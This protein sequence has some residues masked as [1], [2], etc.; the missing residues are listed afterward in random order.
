MLPL[1]RAYA[2]FI[3]EK[4]ESVTEPLRRLSGKSWVTVVLPFGFTI[5]F[6]LAIGPEVQ[7]HTL[8]LVTADVP[9]IYE[10]V[11]PDEL[12][13]FP[14]LQAWLLE[15]FLLD[16]IAIALI[17]TFVAFSYRT[18]SGLLAA[19][20][21]ACFLAQTVRDVWI[22]AA[23]PE[24]NLSLAENL[25]GNALGSIA[26]AFV[27]YGTLALIWF[28]RQSAAPAALASSIIAASL[29]GVAISTAVHFGVRVVYRPL[30]AEVQAVGD[31]PLEGSYVPVDGPRRGSD[32]APFSLAPKGSTLTAIESISVRKAGV[33]S[34]RRKSEAPTYNL[35]VRLLEGCVLGKD[36]LGIDS[37]VMLSKTGVSAVKLV[38]GGDNITIS[39]PSRMTVHH[40]ANEGGNYWIKPGDKPAT[41]LLSQFVRER[42]RFTLGADKQL[43]IVSVY[44]LLSKESNTPKID[45]VNRSIVLYIDGLKYRIDAKARS[46]QRVDTK[47]KCKY[48]TK[49]QIVDSGHDSGFVRIAYIDQPSI[50]VSLRL[51]RS[52][53]PRDV[54]RDGEGELSLGMVNGWVS[55]MDFETPYRNLGNLDYFSI[56]KGLSSVKIDGVDRAVSAGGS[57]SMVGQV[58]PEYLDGGGLRITATADAAWLDGVAVNRTRWEQIDGGWKLAIIGAAFAALGALFQLARVQ[59]R[60]RAGDDP[61]GW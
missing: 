30:P 32:S 40:A 8:P 19:A 38:A 60:G 47:I 48:V 33:V 16:N 6:L 5:L 44:Y 45:R 10:A 1:V 13:R 7:R 11:Y 52:E 28:A 23:H 49:N 22:I 41:R 53:V 27:A 50:A 39:S 36:A 24:A 20:A 42:D 61:A 25:V 54:L 18:V 58:R 21:A 51:V 35:E 15:A 57:I 29:V 2:A 56:E 37:P 4:L 31:V 26:V 55:M 34:W 12:A 9:R 17:V 14:S 3:V 43:N 59:L 46:G